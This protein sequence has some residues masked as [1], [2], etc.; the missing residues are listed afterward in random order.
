MCFGRTPHVYTPSTGQGDCR[1]TTPITVRGVGVMPCRIR[2]DA[3]FVPIIQYSIATSRAADS[4][5]TVEAAA[6]ERRRVAV[7]V[8]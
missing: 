8:W 4:V 6:A 7:V 5:A 2:R 1:W 3:S